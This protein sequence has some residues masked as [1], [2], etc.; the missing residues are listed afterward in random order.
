MST[1]RPPRPETSPA[2]PPAP[3]Y[4]GQ[5]VGYVRVSTVDQIT[6]RQL[7]GIALDRVFEDKASGKDVNRPELKALMAHVRAGDTVVVHSIDRLARDLRDLQA[8]VEALTG[9]GVSV[10]FI[11]ESLTLSP[12]GSSPMSTLMLQMLGSFAQFELSMIRERQREGI[13]IAKAA[14]KYR[15][16][17]AALSVDQQARLKAAVAAGGRSKAEVAREFGISRETL[18]SYLRPARG[19][20]GLANA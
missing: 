19:T 16:R 6:D 18:Y 8:T 3:A 11:K 2:S 13:A 14:G 15:G 7:D 10:R 20:E 12:D 9:R 4:R 5:T 17:K 1:G